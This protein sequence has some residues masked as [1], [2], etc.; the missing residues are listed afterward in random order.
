MGIELNG[1][2][3][4]LYRSTRDRMV[5]G[6]AAGLGDYLGVDATAIRLLWVV[7]TFVSG[8]VAPLFYLAAWWLMPREDELRPV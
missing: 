5:S 7:A 1:G 4:H 2:P 8:P 6:V 3:R